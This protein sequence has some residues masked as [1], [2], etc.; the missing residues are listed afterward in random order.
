MNDRQ[1]RVVINGQASSWGTITAGIPR[2]SVLGPLL[3]LLFINDITHVINHCNIRLFADDTCLF[4]EVDNCEQASEQI[5]ADLDAIHKWSKNW[6]VTFSPVK[7]KSLII[8]N[9]KDANPPA[10]L[11]NHVIEDVPAH[12][13]L[14]LKFANNLGGTTIFMT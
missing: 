5:N 10:M 12:T 1:Q 11:N 14:G 9:K 13:Y 4:I 7:T 3:F 8:S 2:G 6:L